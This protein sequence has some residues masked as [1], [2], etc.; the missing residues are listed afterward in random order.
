M[1]RLCHASCF[2]VQ[3]LVQLGVTVN[4]HLYIATGKYLGS[5]FIL[6]QTVG[7]FRLPPSLLTIGISPGAQDIGACLHFPLGTL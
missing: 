5:C 1:L 2:V 6:N 4:R 7:P 3:E